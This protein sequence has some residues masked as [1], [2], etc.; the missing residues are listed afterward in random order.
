VIDSIFIKFSFY[1]SQRDVLNKVY[2]P[3]D[4]EILTKEDKFLEQNDF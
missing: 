3:E 2:G 4:L 1:L